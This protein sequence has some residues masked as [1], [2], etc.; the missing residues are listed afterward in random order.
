[1]SD[2]LFAMAR[3]ANHDAGVGDVPWVPA[4]RG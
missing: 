2:L 4:K 3:R 1:M